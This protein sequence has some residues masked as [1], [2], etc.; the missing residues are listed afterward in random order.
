MILDNKNSLLNKTISLLKQSNIKLKKKIGQS[1]IVNPDYIRRQIEFANLGSGDIILEIGAGIGNL[2]EAIA[3]LVKKVISIEL[4]SRFKKIL[5]ERLSNFNNIELIFDNAL[6]IDYPFFNKI[7][8]NIP[9]N[10]SSPLTFKL[11]TYKFDLGVLVYQIEFAKRMIAKPGHSNYG[12][13]SINVDLL[14]EVQLLEKIPKVSFFP[15]PKVDSAIIKIIPRKEI[16]IK[17]NI[18]NFFKVVEGIFSYKNKLVRKATSHFLD[19]I[20]INKQIKTKI[21]NQ[22]PHSE[23]RVRYLNI[24]MVDDITKILSKFHLFD[25]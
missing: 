13:L 8:A 23:F 24:E 10:I 20:N 14:A 2:T 22:I 12:R 1:F 4:D 15:Q 17:T 25:E 19:N 7:V 6:E 16:K 21:L 9:Y 3:P 5:E 18:N 11:L